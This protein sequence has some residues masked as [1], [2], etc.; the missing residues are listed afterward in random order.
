MGALGPAELRLMQG[1]AQRVTALRLELVNGDATV[2]ELAWVW[3]KDFDALNQCWRHR[4]WFVDGQLAGWGWV[5]LPYRVP[6]SDGKLLEVK[7]ANLIW[8][9]HPDQPE[10]LTEI[11]DWYDDVAVG[12][13]RM[14]CP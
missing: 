10:L 14:N 8:Q 5:Y 2:G 7:A 6:R 1:L 3:A 11:L 13:T 9:V 4:L 12:P